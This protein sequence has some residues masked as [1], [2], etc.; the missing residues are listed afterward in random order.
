MIYLTIDWYS[1]RHNNKVL[2][3]IGVCDFYLDSENLTVKRR[4][5]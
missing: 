1:S 5:F 4:P 3:F 2:F